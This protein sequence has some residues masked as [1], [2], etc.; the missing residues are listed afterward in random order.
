MSFFKYK[1][2]I[3]ILI[4]FIE[5]ISIVKSQVGI[6]TESP[7]ATLDVAIDSNISTPDGLLIPR[8]TMSQLYER[9]DTYGSD[10]HG[11]MIY[12]TD[13]DTKATTSK[14]EGITSPGFYFFNS[15]ADQWQQ[16]GSA[17]AL[18]IYNSDGYL[19]GNRTVDLDSKNLVFSNTGNVGIGTPSP[20]NKLHISG[21]DPL[22]LEQ[23]TAGN[24]DSDKIVVI[25]ANGVI[26]SI[27]TIFDIISN[28]GTPSPALFELESPI[29]DF[30]ATANLGEKQKVPMS[31]IKNEINGLTLSDDGTVITFPPGTYQLSF[32]YEALH[33]TDGTISSYLVDFPTDGTSARIHSTAAHKTGPLS[34]HGGVITFVTSLSKTKDWTIALGRGQSGDCS[35]SGLTLFDKSTQL[36]VYRLGN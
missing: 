34:N 9:S 26:K 18:N 36:L 3:F 35:G 29:T 11:I 2:F 8:L 14:T 23:L 13:L 10:Q 32:I 5:S 22:R 24:E 16:L 21:S 28:F 4:C 20:T 1:K 19:T 7:K 6:N 31:A 30:L 27:G 15:K 33:N 17:A 12:I 25:D